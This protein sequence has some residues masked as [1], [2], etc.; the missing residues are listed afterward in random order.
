MYSISKTFVSAAIGVMC[1]EGKIHLDDKVCS[2]FPNEAR[3]VHP[4]LAQAT[5]RDL[6][7]M[8]TPHESTSYYLGAPDWTATFFEKKPDHPPGTVFHYDT[9]GSYILNVIVE[10][11]T[12]RP[13]LEYLYDKALQYT[14]FSSDAWC[15][16]APEGNS[17]GGSGVMC[18]T[19]DLARLALLFLNGGRVNG[20]QVIP[21]DYVCAAT[22]RQIANE[23]D[24][25]IDT[26]HGYG[27]GY[28]IWRTMNG[29]FS[30]L[31]M[32]DQLAICVPEQDI[33]FVCTAD[34]QGYPRARDIIFN[35]VWEYIV[36]PAE[37]QAIPENPTAFS[38]LQSTLSGLKLPL[39]VGHVGHS[40]LEAEISGKTFTMNENRMKISSIRFDFK[41][42]GGVISYMTPRG[43]KRLTFG[44]GHYSAGIFPET[45]YSGDT[46]GV[47]A[48][49][50]YEC[51]TAAVWAE[52]NKLVLR[53][54]LA[55]DHLGNL[56]MNAGFKD[57]Q[58]GLLLTKNAEWFLEEYY[59]FA[60]GR[61]DG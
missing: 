29:S 5:I 24:L 40:P 8:A 47:P 55:D 27:Y 44:L 30:F 13:F 9:G 51:H 22:T 49:R 53:S 7:V 2:Y 60:G 38:E 19:R 39:P 6:L 61:A 42:D 52:P 1:G 17:W 16:K 3:N 15:I 28:Q 10:R 11:V 48:H 4:Y 35:S 18:T 12:G 34:N 37:K 33:L 20:R 32:G 31:G 25:S 54:F 45:H 56:T 26:C 46:I 21:E 43:E 36:N 58:L 57:G 41:A 23:I 14:G 59:G 50:G